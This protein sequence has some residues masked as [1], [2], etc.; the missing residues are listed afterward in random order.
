MPI[1]IDLAQF[2]R[3]VCRRCGLVA[4]VDPSLPADDRGSLMCPQCRGRLGKPRIPAQLPD[5]PSAESRSRPAAPVAVTP[6]PSHAA[7][8][9]AIAGIFLLLLVGFFIF[10]L[11]IPHTAHVN[12]YYP[13]P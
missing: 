7:V 13:K 5:E 4:L 11:L 1:Q 2:P 3:L 12:P 6:V 9:L 8:T 10:L